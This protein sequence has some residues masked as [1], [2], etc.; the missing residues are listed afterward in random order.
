MNWWHHRSISA[1]SQVVDHFSDVRNAVSSACSSSDGQKIIIHFP[2]CFP[3]KTDQMIQWMIGQKW[4]SGIKRLLYQGSRYTMQW[5]YEVL[6]EIL[7]CPCHMA[8]SVA[9][10]IN[11]FVNQ[12]VGRFFREVFQ[13]ICRCGGFS[14][15]KLY[16]TGVEITIFALRLGFLHVFGNRY[17]RGC[18]TELRMS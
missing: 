13:N 3:T 10:W 17:G 11:L 14:S 4:Y 9:D 1:P 7:T 16:K 2:Y 6:D 8:L 15:R 18:E 12:G 5:T